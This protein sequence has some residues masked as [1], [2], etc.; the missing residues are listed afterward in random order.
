MDF[1]TKAEIVAECWMIVRDQEA[2]QELLKY[3][4]LGFPLAYSHVNKIA[5]LEEKGTGFVEDVYT[6]MVATLGIPDEEYADFEAML[7][8]NIALNENKDD[9]VDKDS[10]A[11]ESNTG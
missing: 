5:T 10:S 2:W 9:D 11:E 3:G 6:V 1:D 4:D 7:D 8:K